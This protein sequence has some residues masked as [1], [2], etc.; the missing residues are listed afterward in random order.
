MIKLMGKFIYLF[1]ILFIPYYTYGQDIALNPILA[2][3]INTL[4]I[5]FEAS[6]EEIVH[7]MRFNLGIRVNFENEVRNFDSGRLSASQV[8][9]MSEENPK[10]FLLPIRQEYLKWI[11]ETISQG[12]GNSLVDHIKP[13]ILL[14]RQDFLNLPFLL[15]KIRNTNV[16]DIHISNGSITIYPKN[17]SY[18]KVLAFSGT[19]DNLQAL[20]KSLIPILQ[21]RHLNLRISSTKREFPKAITLHFENEDFREFLSR[22]SDVLGSNYVWSILG[23]KNARHISFVNISNNN[24]Y[25]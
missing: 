17:I 7:L 14:K 21:E 25:E 13:Y 15:D 3:R 22:I 20:Q 19:F 18:K 6:I 10:R 24:I 4:P 11:K 8:L 5:E 2:S 12:K 9:K 23:Y 1:F 16:Y